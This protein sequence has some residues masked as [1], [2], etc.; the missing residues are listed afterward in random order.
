MTDFDR[1]VRN[2]SISETLHPYSPTEL[3]HDTYKE[4]DCSFCHD[5]NEISSPKTYFKALRQARKTPGKEWL[6]TLTFDEMISD[7][8]LLKKGWVGRISG[9]MFYTLDCPCCS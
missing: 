3:E 2:G 1:I 6:C 4:E 5:T 9:E 7:Y 8:R